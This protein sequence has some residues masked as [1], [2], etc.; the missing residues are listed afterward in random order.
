MASNSE[1]SVNTMVAAAMKAPSG[2]FVDGPTATFTRIE[3]DDH[4]VPERK[5]A[6][7]DAD[8]GLLTVFSASNTIKGSDEDDDFALI[9][10]RHGCEAVTEETISAEPVEAEPGVPSPATCKKIIEVW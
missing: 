7:E 3:G 2:L 5:S 8:E 4:C 10:A 1:A 6:T 9:G